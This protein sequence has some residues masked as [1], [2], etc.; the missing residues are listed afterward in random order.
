MLG[1]FLELFGALLLNL[2]LHWSE[3]HIFRKSS[4]LSA[5]CLVFEVLASRGDVFFW[6]LFLIF[7]T[8]LFEFVFRPRFS[9]ILVS[10]WERFWD[11]LWQNR[12]R[13]NDRQNGHPPDANETLFTGPEAP[14]DTPRV[15]VFRTRN[16]DSSTS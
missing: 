7:S 8:A 13:K 6:L 2:L 1:S 16:N 10:F 4:P 3:M 14:G 5:F 9:L 12:C 15:R 11:Q